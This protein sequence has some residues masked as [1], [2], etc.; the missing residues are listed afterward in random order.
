MTRNLFTISK[1]AAG[2]YIFL[3]APIKLW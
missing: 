1:Q 2:D 3:A